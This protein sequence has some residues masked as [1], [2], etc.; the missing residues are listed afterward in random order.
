MILLYCVLFQVNKRIGKKYRNYTQEMLAA[1][2]NDVK[3]GKHSV[4]RAARIHGVPE[5]TL[6]DKIK[7]RR[8]LDCTQ[9]RSHC[10]EEEEE[11]KILDTLEFYGKNGYKYKGVDIMRIATRFAVDFRKSICPGEDKEDQE[12][13][14]R[15]QRGQKIY[16]RSIRGLKLT[17]KWFDGFYQRWKERI[18]PY[19]IPTNKTGKPVEMP[20]FSEEILNE[21]F[22]RY[23][24]SLLENN[25]IDKPENIFF[26]EDIRL[27]NSIVGPRDERI[28]KS[29]SIAAVSNLAG[30]SF[31]PYFV[32]EAIDSDAENFFEEIM[33][34]LHVGEVLTLQ[35][36]LLTCMSEAHE[37]SPR[38]L[39]INGDKLFVLVGIE[40]W[41]KEHNI[42]LLIIPDNLSLYIRAFSIAVEGNFQKLVD[43]NYEISPDLSAAENY[44]L[45]KSHVD[46]E[47][48]NTFTADKLKSSFS[49]L[50]LFPV[51][52]KAAKTVCSQL[53]TPLK[54]SKIFC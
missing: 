14:P 47:F 8:K 46:Q 5:E 12:S 20:E 17:R 29:V 18:D 34:G 38:V 35:E 51:D 33:G 45:F 54:V 30:R 53:P 19:V 26:V 7:G 32:K 52:V 16:N 9:G 42:R 21:L 10:F 25:L 11:H 2:F 28:Q 15:S 41:A 48:T 1:A 4:L 24:T 49:K 37:D 3:S 50:G 6:R 31:P 43:E 23:E 27:L 36:H 13:F 44:Q 22:N 39:L 40:E